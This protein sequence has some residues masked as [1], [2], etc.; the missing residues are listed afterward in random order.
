MVN[1]AYLPAIVSVTLVVYLLVVVLVL[2]IFH[3]RERGFENNVDPSALTTALLP[4]T[5]SPLANEYFAVSP[6]ERTYQSLNPYGGRILLLATRVLSFCYIFGI[7]GLWN[8]YTRR[9]TN[10]FY[11]THW[12]LIMISLYY[13]SGILASIVGILFDAKFRTSG[14]VTEDRWP[15]VEPS[16]T[17]PDEKSFWSVH[18]QRLGF[19]IQLL[20]EVAGGSAFFITFIAFAFLSP[21]FG[22]GNVNS[23]FVT[24]MTFLLELAQNAMIVR[25]HHV[26]LNVFWFVLYLLYIWPAVASGA[27]TK[28]PYGFL[29]TEHPDCFGWYFLLFLLNVA[30]YFVW[31]YLSRVK[32]E[33]VY[34]RQES[35]RGVLCEHY[36]MLGHQCPGDVQGA[37]GGSDGLEVPTP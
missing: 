35:A 1:Q 22:L 12:N 36:R 26:L 24:S 30:F 4:S 28:W 27:V 31:Y 19:I 9:F 8:W 11:F 13:A 32:Y 37:D 17:V 16:K 14:G 2:Y 21:H 10:F 3:K 5:K 25:W 20:F 23:H 18:A 33:C 29:Q 6:F 7:S 34:A 15:A